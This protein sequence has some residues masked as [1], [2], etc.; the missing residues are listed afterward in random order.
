MKNLILSLFVVIIIPGCSTFESNELHKYNEMYET[1]TPIFMD[2]NIQ[3]VFL[4]GYFKDVSKIDSVFIMGYESQL[5]VDK[6]WLSLNPNEDAEKLSKLS[7]WIKG[8]KYTI[9][10]LNRSKIQYNF[11]FDAANLSPETVKIT[12]SFTNWSPEGYELTFKNGLWQIQLSLNP[13]KY[14]YQ[15][16]IDDEWILDPT[17]SIKES[18]NIGGFNSVLII[19]DPAQHSPK[20]Y[21][22]RHE[23]NSLIIGYDGEPEKIVALVDNTETTTQLTEG[24]IRINLPKSITYQSHAF[25][26]VWAINEH[27]YSNDLLIPYKDGEIIANIDQINRFDKHAQVLYFM[28]VDRFN[29][30]NK[31]N[32]SPVDD[33]EI[34]YKANYQGGDLA[35]VQTKIDDGYFE[36]LGVNMLWLSPITQNPLEGFIEFPSPHRKYSGYH[37]YWPVTLTTIDHRFGTKQEMHSLVDRAHASDMNLILDFVSNHVHE[38]NKLI[39]DN[40][41]WATV[42]DLPDGSKNIRIWDEQRLTTWFDTFLPSLN[43]EITEVIDQISDSAKFWIDEYHI[44]GFRHDATKHI[45]VEYWRTLTK[46]IRADKNNDFVFQIGE[47]FGSREL[48]RSYVGTDQ[49]DGQFDFNLYFDLRNVFAQDSESFLTIEQSIKESLS[50]YNYH[51]LMGNLTGNHDLPRFISYAGGALN[52]DEDEKEAGWNRDIQVKDT[53]GYDKL[54]S[55]TAFIMTFPGV[56]VIYYGDEI[57]MAGAGDPDNRR[58][59]KFVG[60]TKHEKDVKEKAKKLI[61]LRKSKLSL[62]YGDFFMIESTDETMIYARKYFD[63]VCIIAF[64]KSKESKS[65]TV[66]LPYY[67]QSKVWQSNFGHELNY[68]AAELSIQMNP[69][70][71][72]IIN[73]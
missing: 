5:S 53:I 37:G 18:N 13:G 42:L 28:L 57:G 66:T 48:I 9:V 35:G 7:I 36:D 52:Y 70:S 17:N 30:G 68:E 38:Q 6:K 1:A 64:N 54:S 15:L 45:P 56:P 32:D 51:S 14:P 19:E 2:D 67:L 27:G 34:E 50:Y 12:G 71:F 65:I 60:L 47:T 63:D 39:Q 58:M 62:I 43:F 26:R 41:D 23:K 8:D 69:Y 22:K 3:K 40:P 16:V 11:S 20:I 72:E 25:I 24:E 21:T 55:L 59:M 49:L 46:K 61:S 10:V 33:P 29:N 44:D 31:S 73:N 4:D